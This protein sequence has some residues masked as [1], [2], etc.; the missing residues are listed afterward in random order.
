MVHFRHYSLANLDIYVG[1]TS[2]FHSVL[3]QVA[4]QS[5]LDIKSSTLTA[6][7]PYILR[8][9][10]SE[11]PSLHTIRRSLL[12]LNGSRIGV[13]VEKVGDYQ[14]S[15]FRLEIPQASMIDEALLKQALTIFLSVLFDPFIK[16]DGFEK[17]W[18]A[19]EIE[20]MKNRMRLFEQEP[21]FYAKG[22][23]IQEAFADEHSAAN[24]YGDIRYLSDVLPKVL[25]HTYTAIIQRSPIFVF[26]V[27]NL[28]A[29]IRDRLTI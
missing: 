12:Q 27:G 18:V 5:P 22:R 28:S 4:I 1:E 29:T 6:L 17:S 21:Y 10:S 15:I 20:I 7:I 16:D 14:Y 25:Y 13:D 24:K 19:N 2:K 8:C 3:V 26:A 9:G 11:Y 23:C